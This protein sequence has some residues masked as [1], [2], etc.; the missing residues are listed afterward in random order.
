MLGFFLN[1]FERGATHQ[2]VLWLV[3]HT[4]SSVLGGAP[5]LATQR[6]IE[7]KATLL[8]APL[9]WAT[10]FAATYLYIVAL[11]MTA[12]LVREILDGREPEMEPQFGFVSARRANILSVS[13]KAFAVL[14]VAILLM[15]ALIVPAVHLFKREISASS[16]GLAAA[17]LA[18]LAVAFFITPRALAL[19]SGHQFPVSAKQISDARR[20]GML[21]V[22]VSAAVGY[23]CE[24][25]ASAARGPAVPHL[26]FGTVDSLLSALPFIPLFVFLS[27][28]ALGS[29]EL[30]IGAVVESV[31]A[32]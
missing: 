16:I 22:T 27:L 24:V 13:I 3:S 17:L 11:V 14:V 28:T 10:Y 20:F 30:K 32:E 2:F 29:E 12:G 31:D 8:T 9:L 6:A 1:Q 19:I 18:S 15:G 4:H 25:A 21:A 7:L 5:D 23:L 26:V